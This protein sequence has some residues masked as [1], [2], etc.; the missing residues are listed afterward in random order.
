MKD[1]KT[2]TAGVL[3]ILVGFI[4]FVALPYLHG[5]APNIA[6]FLATLAPG[7]AGILASDSKAGAK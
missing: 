6:G 1:W 3:T 2:S 4:T 5:Q 7:F